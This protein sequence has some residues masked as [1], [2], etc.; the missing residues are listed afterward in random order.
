MSSSRHKAASITILL[1]MT[2]IR[3]ILPMATSEASGLANALYYLIAFSF[4][5]VSYNNFSFISLFFTIYFVSTMN[6]KNVLICI[7]FENWVYLQQAAID[8]I[9]L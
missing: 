5:S 8:I 2:F 6:L 7:L 4:F 9:V 3:D 1:L